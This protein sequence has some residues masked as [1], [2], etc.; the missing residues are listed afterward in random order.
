MGSDEN[1]TNL[2]ADELALLKEEQRLLAEVHASLDQQESYNSHRLNAESIRSLELTEDLIEVRREEDKQLLAS[3]EAVA[4][5]IVSMK[6]THVKEV[7]KV[8]NRPYFAR[9]VLEERTPNGKAREI[10]YKIGTTSNPDCR[11]IDWR[12]APLAKLYYEYNE[13]DE[14]FETIQGREREG[15]IVM[16]NRVEIENG[17]LRSVVCRYGSFLLEEGEWKRGVGS[18]SGGGAGGLPDVLSLI[19]KEQFQAITEDAESAVIIQGVA[20]SGKTTVALYRLSWLVQDGAEELVDTNCAI[21]VRSAA[22]ASYIKHSL[23]FLQL[24][25]VSVLTYQ[26]FV[27]TALK[28]LLGKSEITRPNELTHPGFV[29]LKHSLAFKE[30]IKLYVSSQYQRVVRHLQEQ[31]DETLLGFL[32]EQATAQPLLVFLTAF[33][34][35]IDKREDVTQEKRE[36]LDRVIK[37]VQLYQEDIIEILRRP[38]VII[39]NDRTGLIDRELIQRALTDAIKNKESSQIAITDDAVVLFLASCKSGKL[40]KD[41]KLPDYFQHLVI[42]EVQDFTALELELV[43]SLVKKREQL[44][45]AGDVSQN[46]REENTFPGWEVLRSHWGFD[47]GQH[48]FM[49]LMISYR[50]TT[51]IMRVADYVIGATQTELGRKGSRPLWFKCRTEQRGVREAIGWLERIIEKYPNDLTAVICPSNEEVQYV[52]SLLEPTFGFIVRYGEGENFSFEEGVVVTTPEEVKG[53]EFAHVLIWNPSREFYPKQ[54]RARNSLYVACTRA[55]D[56]LCFVSWDQPTHLLPH[57]HSKLLR[58]IELEL[59]EEE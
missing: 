8:R 13:G 42:D 30:A 53:L 5:Q 36:A 57:I 46:L 4:Q 20:G 33:K 29:R 12:K 32:T 35:F 38:E 56:H 58:G 16:R 15:R 1:Q 51:A 25:G 3:D 31:F 49:E 34:D 39:Q 21:L 7:E 59:E 52:V 48:R 47:Q 6:M 23:P 2:S 27:E 55:Q 18:R 11:I 14:Y 45:I 26:S 17:V 37:R 24:E 40:L 54:T 28:L 19:T 9:V 50:S 44:T 41:K 22:L 10:E 43:L